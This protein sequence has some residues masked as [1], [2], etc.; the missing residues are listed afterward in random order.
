MGRRSR[1]QELFPAL[2]KGPLTV[3]RPAL[4][5]GHSDRHFRRMIH[6]LVGYANCVLGVRDC[7]AALLGITG[8]QYEILMVVYRLRGA[9]PCSVSEV[10]VEIHRTIAFVTNETKKLAARGLIAKRGDPRDGR[11]INLT[12]TTSCVVAL[13]GLAPVQRT[14][15]DALFQDLNAREFLGLCQLY[16]KLPAC[17]ERALLL[18]ESYRIKNPARNAKLRKN[19]GRSTISRTKVAA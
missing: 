1:G 17:G 2:E 3:S 19:N 7:F 16:E 10:A 13:K 4:L 8:A 12:V 5:A 15:N 18:A 6:A 14:L 11:R 9:K